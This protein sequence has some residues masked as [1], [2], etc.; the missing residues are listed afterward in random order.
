MKNINQ[1]YLMFHNNYS[2]FSEKMQKCMDFFTYCLLRLIHF[3]VPTGINLP[4][5]PC[6]FLTKTFNRWIVRPAILRLIQILETK[7]KTIRNFYTPIYFIFWVMT[8]QK[9][10]TPWSAFISNE[11]YVIPAAGTANLNS[12]LEFFSLVCQIRSS[13][14]LECKTP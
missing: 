7:K 3:K 2:T 4:N 12:R 10:Q 14:T 13:D 5:I 11:K 9:Y 6:L 8:T 1:R